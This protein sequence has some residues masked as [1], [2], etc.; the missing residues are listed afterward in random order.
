MLTASPLL[1]GRPLAAVAA[2]QETS[3]L[4]DVD[5]AQELL[6]LCAQEAHPLILSGAWVGPQCGT[7]TVQGPLWACDWRHGQI[8]LHLGDT[9]L[10][11][12][13]HQ[14]ARTEWRRWRGAL[15]LRQGLRLWDAEH[16]VALTIGAPLRSP[17]CEG[18]L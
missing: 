1:S 4:L 8:T 10:C 6:H 17:H 9:S 2:A 3:L 15:G 16:T 14:V 18:A 5:R 7:D 13:E 12:H 11:W